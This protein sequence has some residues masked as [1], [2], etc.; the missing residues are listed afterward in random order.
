MQGNSPRRPGSSARKVWTGFG[1]SADALSEMHLHCN[2]HRVCA[3]HSQTSGERLRRPLG[4]S[5][6]VHVACP[7]AHRPSTPSADLIVTPPHSHPHMLAHT[8]TSEARPPP[9]SAHTPRRSKRQHY[10][11]TVLGPHVGPYPTRHPGQCGATWHCLPATRHSLRC[12]LALPT[13]Y[14]AQAAAVQP[15]CYSNASRALALT[16]PAPTP[17]L[18]VQGHIP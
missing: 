11:G 9:A 1:S 12:H 17:P 5:S 3:A 14:Q 6:Q 16:T 18:G 7:C 8:Q 15:A 10:H 4:H 13:S 2:S